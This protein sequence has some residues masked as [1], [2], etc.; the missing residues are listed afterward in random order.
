MDQRSIQAIDDSVLNDMKISGAPGAVI[1]IVKNG[2]II[3]QKAYGIRDS[4][5]RVPVTNSTLFLIASV[6][7][8]FTT[9][10]L[11]I[12]CEKNNIDVNTPVGNIIK[13]LSPKLSQLTIHQILS[14]SSGMLDHWPTRKK[15]KNDVSEYFTHYGD[16]LVCEELT[17]IF[18]Y[19]NFGHVLAGWILATLNDSSFTDA[20]DELIF[21]PLK[22]DSS[23]FDVNIAK[24]NNYSAGHINGKSVTHKLTYPLIQPSASM[25]SNIEDL[26]RFAICFMN[27]GEIDNQQIISSNVIKKMSTNYTP[28]EVLR[29][30]FGYPVSSYNYGLIGFNFK[31]IDF[32]GHPGESVSQNVLFAMAPEYK[33]AFILLSNTGYYPFIDSFEKMVTTILPVKKDTGTKLES[34]VNM[35]KFTG[36]YYTPNIYGTKEDIIEIEYRFKKLYIRFSDEEVYPLTFNGK[37]RFYYKSPDLKF[38]LEITFYKDENGEIKYLNNFWKISIKM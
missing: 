36:K 12:A 4:K 27:D 2:N 17:S 26:S 28:I 16:K 22:M 32:V 6:T 21:K 24:L 9:T 29:E 5:T 35:N 30:Y 23:T 13:G 8:V 15:Y 25:F 33:S 20:I 14:Q 38:P 31:G 10:A 11:L 7:K 19:T 3:Y 37:S 34:A 1:G 18:S